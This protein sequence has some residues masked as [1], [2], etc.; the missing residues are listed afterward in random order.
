MAQKFNL[1]PHVQTQSTLC[2]MC[3]GGFPQEKKRPE[4]E[5]DHLP[6]YSIE[7]KNVR[8]HTST[9]PYAFKVWWSIKHRD[10]FIFLGAF[11]QVRKATLASSYLSVR[12]HGTTRLPLGGCSW[13]LVFEYFSENCW[14]NSIFIKIWHAYL[15]VKMEQSVPK[16]RHINFRRRGISQ[17]KG[18]LHE[19]LC[20][21]MI[22][23]AEFFEWE[24]FQ[25]AIVEKNKTHILRSITSPP[26][27][28]VPI[29]RC[30]AGQA[31]DNNSAHAHCMP[32]N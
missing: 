17:N 19:D 23:L 21:F 8:S 32:D 25:T 7:V 24:I 11:A 1:V 9:V 18:T 30:R 20:T 3:I 26:L 10:S 5:A 28:I 4:P 2:V 31:T 27:K 13:H 6:A 16:R 14:E 15:P 29:L 22:C 12:L